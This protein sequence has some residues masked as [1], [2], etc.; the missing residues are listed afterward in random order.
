M[1]TEDKDKVEIDT[2]S[3]N[4]K[5]TGGFGILEIMK[6]FI[7][8]INTKLISIDLHIGNISSSNSKLDNINEKLDTTIKLLEGL[9]E[10]QKDE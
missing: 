7:V 10:L 8:D 3:D 6:H 9:V 1:N 5:E 4:E 2:E